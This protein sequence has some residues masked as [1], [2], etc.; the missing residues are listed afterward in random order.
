MIKAIRATHV[1]DVAIGAIFGGALG[2]IISACVIFLIGMSRLSLVDVWV[3]NVGSVLLCATL[4]IYQIQK[5]MA[6]FQPTASTTMCLGCQCA[7]RRDQDRLF[8][9]VCADG[10]TPAKAGH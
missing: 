1:V 4:L 9:P 2:K 10:L 5:I 7:V 8:C 6:F 3:L